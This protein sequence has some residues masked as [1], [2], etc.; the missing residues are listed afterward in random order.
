MDRRKRATLYQT[1][2]SYVPLGLNVEA[3][4]GSAY[5]RAVLRVQTLVPGIHFANFA[6]TEI[7]D[8]WR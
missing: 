8:R 6:I 2:G 4:I 3:I 5:M 7:L 1:L